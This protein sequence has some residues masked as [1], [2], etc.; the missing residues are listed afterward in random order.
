[1]RHGDDTGVHTCM[2]ICPL[3]TV[4]NWQREWVSWSQYVGDDEEYDVSFIRF[5]P[6]EKKN[7][8]GVSGLRKEQLHLQSEVV[9]QSANDLLLLGNAGV[10]NGNCKVD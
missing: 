4:L 6:E 2:V 8:G 5:P 7:D 3:N 1:M 9:L 10:R